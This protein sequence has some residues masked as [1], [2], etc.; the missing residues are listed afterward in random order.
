MRIAYIADAE[1]P[2]L[3]NMCPR[4]LYAGDDPLDFKAY[5]QL[6]IRE[7]LRDQNINPDGIVIT[8]RDSTDTVTVFAQPETLTEMR[9]IN[10][11]H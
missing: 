2:N 7:R 4:E 8:W 5:P 11:V 1:M 10:T 3:E 6:F 9:S